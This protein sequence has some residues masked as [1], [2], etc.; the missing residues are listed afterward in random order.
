MAHS[1]RSGGRDAGCSSSTLDRAC[2]LPHRHGDVK[3][4]FYFYV[5]DANKQKEHLQTLVCLRVRHGR[6]PIR[7]C[8]KRPIRS[9]VFYHPG[10][11]PAHPRSPCFCSSQATLQESSASSPL[12]AWSVPTTAP[13]SS[14]QTLTGLRPVRLFSGEMRLSVICMKTSFAFCKLS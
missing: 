6:A 2:C 5:N 8:A 1:R 13:L 3:Q 4:M 10:T 7:S 14:P 9:V 11:K 12:F